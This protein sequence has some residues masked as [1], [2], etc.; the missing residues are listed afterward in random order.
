MYADPSNVVEFPSHRLRIQLSEEELRQVRIEA[1][2]ERVSVNT[3]LRRLLVEG[4]E[5]ELS[6]D[7]SS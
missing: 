5:R 6:M 4:A 7:A 1:A 2:I 3:M